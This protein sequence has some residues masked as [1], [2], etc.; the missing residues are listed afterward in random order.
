MAMRCPNCSN[1][2]SLDE[3]FCG[4]CGTPIALSAKPVD[5]TQRQGLLSSGYYG[6]TSST[7]VPSRTGMSS[8]ITNQPPMMPSAPHQNGFH[9]DPTEAMTALPTQPVPGYPAQYAQ[10]QFGNPMASSGYSGTGQYA[11]QIQP[12]QSGNYTATMFP[13]TQT[14]ANEQGNG[15]PPGITPPP[16]KKQNNTTLIILSMCIV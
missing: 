1:E 6:S 8:P 11:P 13:T 2:I 4:Q 5:P 3:T 16:P 14:P 9:Q 7:S 15:V 12:L 10:Q